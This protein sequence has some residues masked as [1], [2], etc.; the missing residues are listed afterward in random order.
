MDKVTQKNLIFGEVTFKVTAEH[1]S[2][3]IPKAVEKAKV[4]FERKISAKTQIRHLY[5]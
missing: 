4:E 3:T 2:A 5:V 1:W